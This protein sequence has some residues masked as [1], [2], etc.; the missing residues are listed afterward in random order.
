MAGG[1]CRWLPAAG[2]AGIALA[3]GS[4]NGS[5]TAKLTRLH[6]WNSAEYFGPLIIQGCLGLAYNRVVWRHGSR[7]S[8]PS[9]RQLGQGENRPEGTGTSD[10]E[11]G[12]PQK[13]GNIVKLGLP[14][15]GQ[16]RP[17]GEGYRQRSR[18]GQMARRSLSLLK[19]TYCLM[20]TT[21]SFSHGTK[22]QLE[23]FNLIKGPPPSS[24]I[25]RGWVWGLVA[26]GLGSR[27]RLLQLITPQKY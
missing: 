4:K 24:R 18:I 22:F 3:G 27:N 8:T 7:I 21:T 12:R 15:A 13:R 10:D 19:P 2:A 1:L 25:L 20:Q 5:F 23:H 14:D 9:K 16:L 26:T 11:P 17:V 6:R